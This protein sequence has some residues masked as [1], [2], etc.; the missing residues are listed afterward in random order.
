MMNY[1]LDTTLLPEV[2]ATWQ[3]AKGR[4]WMNNDGKRQNHAEPWM[5]YDSERDIT[6]NYYRGENESRVRFGNV[7][8]TRNSDR[9]WVAAGSSLHFGYA[10]YHADID[11]L[12]V[13]VVKYDT[14]RKD[15]KHTWHY[16]GDR[17]FIGHDKSVIGTNGERVGTYYVKDG[18]FA[19]DAKNMLSAIM[20]CTTNDKFVDEIR[21]FVGGN[22]FI[23]GNGTSVKIEYCWHLQ[24]WLTSVQKQRTN[25]KSQ[26][27]VDKLIQMPL[28]SIEG[29]EHKYPPKSRGTSYYYGDDFIY[30]IIYYE[31]INDE[32]SV[33]R[34]LIS[35]NN[36]FEESWR[37]YI[38]DDGTNRI[39]SKSP[40][41]WV[42][43]STPRGWRFR[44]EFYFANADEA[45]EKCDRI[46]YIAPIFERTEN[47]SAIFSTLQFPCIEQ[48]YKMGH[49]GMAVSCATDG[50]PRAYIK[51]AFGG[52]Y[53]D[54]EKNVLRQIGMTKSQLDSYIRKMNDGHYCRSAL[55]VMRET[56]GDDL[57]RIDMQTFDKYFDAINVFLNNCWYV[58]YLDNLDIDKSRFWKNIV[59]LNAK[60]PHTANIVSDTINS[61]RRLHGDR[62]EIDWYFDDYSDIVRAHDALD[63]LVREQDAALRAYYNLSEQ[64]QREQDEKKR[65][66]VD[67]KRKHMEY[68]D[69]EF[70]IRLPKDVNEI[71]SEGTR[72]CICIGGY[73][74][75][76]SR[77]ETNLFFL[78]RKDDETT[79]FYAIEMNNDKNIVQIHG[80][81]NKWLGNNPEAI[82]TVVRWLRK[83]GIKC[84][85]AILTCTARGYGKTNNYITMPIVD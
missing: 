48:L 3:S 16:A 20:R 55:K 44:R 29:L 82:P 47:I 76:H 71:V 18:T 52:Y 14:T 23:I 85:N 46:K 15:C 58:S 56:L 50:T 51:E 79:P 21:K 19:Y 54:K 8:S 33:L 53:N 12:E 78:R 42:P 67:E 28:G 81:S 60:N 24:K 31:R 43:S 11:R 61:Y 57:S 5:K 63:A 45:K 25:G 37:A 66:K 84:D 68:E 6:Y 49:E 26:K 17:F 35:T 36:G 77:G 34:G 70:I 41:G 59:R 62:P 80:H 69:D 83:N 10:K 75:R 74:S 39:A 32:W 73:T 7:W 38:G 9:M 13:A 4:V 72:Q 22:Y 2:W 65:K 64:K 27:L 30:N 40:D 1:E